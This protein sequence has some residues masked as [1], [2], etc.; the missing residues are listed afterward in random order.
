VEVIVGGKNIAPTGKATQSTTSHGAGPARALDGNKSSNWGKGGQTH[1]EENKPN[2]WW[3][4]DLGNA[5]QRQR[6]REEFTRP[7]ERALETLPRRG[8]RVYSLRGDS[9]SESWLPLLGRAQSQVA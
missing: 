3:E 8:V 4:L 7:I 5:G 6:W 1:T 9:P 2:P